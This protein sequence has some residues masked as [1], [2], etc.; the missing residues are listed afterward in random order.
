MPR[1]ARV[2]DAISH[3]GTITT[4][5]PTSTCNGQKIARQGDSVRCSRHGNRVIIGGSSNM[6]CDGVPVA[7]VG[8][9]ISCG[10]VITTGS[11]NTYNG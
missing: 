1:I 11:S 2:G 10:A 7:R 4:G 6:K 8:D 5:S 3:G 9:T